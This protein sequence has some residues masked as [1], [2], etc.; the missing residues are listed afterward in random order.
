ME[1]F[2]FRVDLPLF[3]NVFKY[4]F[5]MKFLILL[6]ILKVVCVSGNIY[7]SDMQQQL[8]TGKVTDSQTGDAMAGVN[9]IVKGTTIGAITSFDGKYSITVPDKN[10]V[11]VFSFIGYGAQEVPLAGKSVIDVALVSE[12]K[13]LEEVVVIGYGTL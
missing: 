4:I 10:T 11:L 1:K 12:S 3:K 8:V 5:I 6:T 13:A 2:C 7:A 9:V